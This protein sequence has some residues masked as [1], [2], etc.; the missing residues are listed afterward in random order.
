MRYRLRRR[1]SYADGLLLP[2]APKP[3]EA[4]RRSFIGTAVLTF[5]LVFVPVAVIVLAVFA[6]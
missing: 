1:D 5:V 4:R 3:T 2:A 6:R